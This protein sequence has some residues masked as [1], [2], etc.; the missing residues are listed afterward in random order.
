MQPDEMTQQTLLTPSVL[1][2]HFLESIL[3]IIQEAFLRQKL[4]VTQSQ[5]QT[6][7]IFQNNI[8]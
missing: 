3:Q 5:E 6:E 2:I 4:T 7:G 8:G 1:F